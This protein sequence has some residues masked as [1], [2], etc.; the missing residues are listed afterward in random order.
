MF[1]AH[2][3]SISDFDGRTPLHLAAAEGHFECVKFLLQSCE[4]PSEP[5]DRY[6]AVTIIKH[7]N[8]CH[9][10]QGAALCPIFI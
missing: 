5:T 10:N 6:A 9:Y 7:T 1:L 4:V 2:D 8:H 3:M